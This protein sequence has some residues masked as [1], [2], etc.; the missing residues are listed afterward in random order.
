MKI[1]YVSIDCG[2]ANTKVCAYDVESSK[3]SNEK[4]TSA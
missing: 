2:K 3:W 1:K 4:V